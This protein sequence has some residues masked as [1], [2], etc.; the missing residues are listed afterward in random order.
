[1]A[2]S[3]DLRVL[4]LAACLVGCA[5]SSAPSVVEAGA[6]DA[7][8][9]ACATTVNVRAQ[10]FGSFVGDAIEAAVRPSLAVSTDEVRPDVAVAAVTLPKPYFAR[11]FALDELC[12]DDRTTADVLRVV[13]LVEVEHH[14]ALRRLEVRHDGGALV[15]TGDALAATPKPHVLTDPTACVHFTPLGTASDLEALAATFAS[16]RPSLRC[17]DAGAPKTLEATIDLEVP[18]PAARSTC[19]LTST[20]LSSTTVTLLVPA[21]KTNLAL[22]LLANQCGGLHETRYT[23]A[24]AVELSA[25][26]MGI[27][28][29]FFYQLGDRLYFTRDTTHVASIELPCASK[30]RFTVKSPLQTPMVTKATLE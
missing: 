26:D 5:K 2:S 8:A 28:S 22:D 20:A 12:I 7:A 13:C 17:G 10:F 24:N 27:S 6:P 29:R 18:P 3:A 9:P 21:T 25:S 15:V 1:M 14:V 16:D 23:N 30:V 19:G 11:D 4:V